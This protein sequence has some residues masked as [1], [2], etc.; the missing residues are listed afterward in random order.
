MSKRVGIIGFGKRISGIV[1]HEFKFYP[2]IEVVAIA[3]IDIEKV[4]KN[5]AELE[6]LDGSK[7]N[8]YTD[9]VEMLDNEKL[10]G[11]FVGTR[12]DLHKRFGVEVLKRNI[13]LFLEKPVVTKIEDYYELKK[14]VEENEAGGITSFPLRI[15]ILLEKV[16]E[17][18]DS[19]V[20]GTLSQIQAYNNVSYGRVYYKDWYRDDSITGGLFLQKST[21]DVD[22]I[23]YVLGKQPVELCAVES[24]MVFKGDKPAGVKCSECPE[25]ETCCESSKVVEEK[26][27]DVAHGEGCSFAKD[28]GNQDS[29]TII[30]RYADGMHAVYTQNFVAR[31][32]AGRRGMRMI[33]HKATLEFDWSKDEMLL[34]HH[35]EH[36]VERFVLKAKAG[37]G[38]SGGDFALIRDFVALMNG[39]KSVSSL[40]DGLQSA[41]I[42]LKARES[43]E[44]HTFVTL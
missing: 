23:N 39:D 35:D 38:H 8:Y 15:T 20:L 27:G 42:C 11:V 32:Q 19:G 28:T 12:C 3:D 31:K 26:I 4:K 17:I 18:Y 37:G 40:K 2:E 13:P 44:T 25:Y 36:R 7:I 41:Y 14:A 34:F 24:K 29:G 1:N 9:A 21:H 22:Y 43:A 10:D 30:M 5:V 33:G 6:V 16:K